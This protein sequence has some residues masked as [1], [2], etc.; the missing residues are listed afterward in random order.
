MRSTGEVVL[1]R[2][3]ES[4][5]NAGSRFTGLLDV[6]LSAEGERQARA[7]GDMLRDAGWVPD[8]VAC[9]PMRRGVHTLDLLGLDGVDVELVWQLA[10]RDYGT[11]TDMPKAE[12]RERFGEDRFFAWRRTLHG[13]P[14]AATPEQLEAWRGREPVGL[15][16][17][18]WL[19]MGESLADVIVRL[20][21]WWRE[22]MVPRL[23]D[24]ARVLVVAHGN[25]LR[26]LVD[27]VTT[28]PDSDIEELNI[29]QAQPLLYFVDDTGMATDAEGRWFDSSAALAAAER[30]AAEGG[31]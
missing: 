7:A 4:T 15:P 3:G 29:P 16:P 30:I 20:E 12:V 8:L 28:G 2:H 9:S 1:L 5:Y 11:L 24:G 18:L 19:G 26:A 23:A 21:P 17:Q 13:Q 22:R 6:P 10:E 14:P 31:T 27:L 25:S